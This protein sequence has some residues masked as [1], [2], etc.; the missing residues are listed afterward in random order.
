MFVW[1]GGKMDTLEFFRR[2]L[3]ED[4]VYCVFVKDSGGKQQSFPS[5]LEELARTVTS[6]NDEGRNVY[7]CISSLKDA[8]NRKGPN[9][10]VTK[11]LALDIDCGE[12]KPYPSQRE[13]LQALLA[14]LQKV[15][16]PDPM[17]VS[18]GNGLHVYWPLTREL[19][20]TE[21]KP[22]ANAFKECLKAN[23]FAHDPNVPA[24]I[25]RVL[26][27][28]GTTNPKGNKPVKLLVDRPAVDPD[29]MRG[30]LASY[31]GLT[32]AA[33]A[34]VQKSSLLDSLAVKQDFPPA[35][36]AVVAKKC[37]Q[38]GWAVAHQDRVDEPLW[39]ALMGVAAHCV[40]PEVVAN[41]WSREHPG[42]SESATLAKLDQWR[43]NT[44]GPA[45]CAKFLELR[46]GGCAGCP[47]AGKIGS[48]VRLGVRYEEVDTSDA[49]PSSAA[50]EVPVPWPFKR[51]SSGMKL[52]LDGTDVDVCRFDIYPVSYGR[53][54]T[55]GY[56][57]VRYKWNRKHVG[58]SDLVLRQGYLAD[59]IYREFV[60]A[61]ADQGIVLPGRKQTE[62]FQMMLRSYMDQLRELRTM[63]NLYASMGWKDDYKTFVWGDTLLRVDDQGGV[64]RDEIKLAGLGGRT[65]GQ[66]FRSSGSMDAWTQ[67]T[68]LLPKGEL[69]CHMFSIGI[70]LASVLYSLSGLKGITVS[71]CGPTGGGKSLAQL[72]QQ[73]LWGDPEKLHFQSKYTSN[74]MFTRL[75]TFANLPVTIDEMTVMPDKE[76]GDFLYMVSQGRD[77]ARLTRAAEE[78]EAKEWGLIVTGSTNRSL[79]SKLAMSGME[80]DAQMARLMELHVEPSPLF[81]KS[82]EI[83]RKL[84]ALITSNF[85]HVGPAFVE[86]LMALGVE[87]V[88]VLAREAPGRMR[89]RYNVKFSGEERFWEQLLAMV[90]LALK[91]AHEWGLVAFRQHECM[92]WALGQITNMRETI[93]ESRE[94]AF[95]LIGAYLNDYAD[96]TVKV[97]HTHGERPIVDHSRIPRGGVFARVD[98]VRKSQ[99]SPFDSGLLLLERTEFRKWLAKR[100]ADYKRFMQ[101]LAE[102]G[103]D[104][105]PRSKKAL[106]GKHTPIQLTQSY[107]IGVNLSHSRMRGLLDEAEQDML[108]LTLN[109]LKVV[110]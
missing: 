41:D 64:T 19:P 89:Q 76:V 10:R 44:T 28:I 71:L 47:F 42:Y 33:V 98:V 16:L 75:G 20:P 26:R 53:D 25:V 99:T 70:G 46:P 49:A 93:V 38:V 92:R 29:D 34:G 43:S 7:Y 69:N 72:M 51:T 73:S 62:Y 56:E 9:V 87:N 109:Q 95:D 39:Y 3:P 65:S 63:T 4:G 86:N 45:T 90:D 24:D 97:M 83:G 52:E 17:I 100:G 37:A 107:V 30:H 88:K 105:T 36:A 67:M 48:P 11:T 106:L 1:Q 103:V 85:G 23:G 74:A 68:G 102:A 22:L 55:L 84:H 77:K 57:V 59:G 18:S 94:D 32:K 66:M 35:L 13:G 12:G 14:F 2:V 96:S 50:T 82:P 81:Q 54:D 104:A 60:G 40:E 80:T 21:W 58:W 8:G 91:L 108:D 61:L 31:Y 6:L 79:A 15:R 78:R 101:E 5:T 27:P 110:K